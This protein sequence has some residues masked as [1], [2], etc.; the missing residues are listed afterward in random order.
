MKKKLILAS[1]ITIILVT[2]DQWTKHLVH[3]NFSLGESKNLLPFFSLTYVQNTGTLFGL[4]SG[5]KDLL[6]NIIL[7]V[8]PVAIIVY[9]LR[10]FWISFKENKNLALTAYVLIL[11][12]AIGN[13][14]DRFTLGYVI[15][16]LDVYIKNYHWPVFNIADSCITIGIC[17]LILEQ[18]LYPHK[19]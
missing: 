3:Q 12:G 4:F 10:Y 15:D 19:A 16:F 2:L 11:A 9:I 5:Q 1:L 18:Y 13:M 17:L 6:R 14:Y 8:L 7:L